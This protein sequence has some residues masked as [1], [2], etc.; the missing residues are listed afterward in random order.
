MACKHPVIF[1]SRDGCKPLFWGAIFWGFIHT[2]SFRVRP[3]P[4]AKTEVVNDSWCCRLIRAFFRL[5]ICAQCRSHA[6]ETLK[7]YGVSNTHS[8]DFACFVFNYHNL[9]NRR[10]GV[11]NFS[12]DE[13]CRRF[14]T[15]ESEGALSLIHI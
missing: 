14:S 15:H 5:L 6:E 1:E 2:L 10:I 12:W 13:C 4:S 7:K 8:E 3:A 11:A 9:V